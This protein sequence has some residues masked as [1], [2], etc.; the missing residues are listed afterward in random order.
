MGG[1]YQVK[2]DFPKFDV[3]NMI[4]IYCMLPLNLRIN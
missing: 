4:Y 2:F 1:F 3:L